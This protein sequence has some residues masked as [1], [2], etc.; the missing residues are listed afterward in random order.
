M[1]TQ[2]A[3]L[4]AGQQ[5]VSL[6]GAF[7]SLSNQVDSYMKDYNQNVWD[8]F[9]SQMATVAVNP[10]GSP[11]AADASPNTAHPISL[12]PPGASAP[13]YV[14]RNALIN[15]VSLIQL[16]Q[17]FMSQAGGTLTMPAQANIKT[18]ALATG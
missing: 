13:L 9:W 16:F 8:T 10:D 3:A 15:G 1:N 18:A 17:T 11:G 4:T 12:T 14:S 5:L 7:E 2:T 6:L